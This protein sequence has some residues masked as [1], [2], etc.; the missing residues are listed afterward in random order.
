MINNRQFWINIEQLK[1]LITPVKRAVK[2]VEFQSTT[3]ADVFVELIKIAVTIQEIPALFNDQFR[4]DCIA[5][6]NKRWKQF[7]TDL[8]LLA[9]FFHPIYR[10]NYIFQLSYYLIIIIII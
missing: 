8:Y 10:G 4:R 3:L 9:Y 2:N 7:D 1:N 5:L 6:Y